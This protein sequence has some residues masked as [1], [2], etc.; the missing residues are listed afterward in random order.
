[1]KK[2]VKRRTTVP[3]NFAFKKKLK[4]TKNANDLKYTKCH[5]WALKILNNNSE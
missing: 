1:M 4:M 5:N 2:R 3:Q